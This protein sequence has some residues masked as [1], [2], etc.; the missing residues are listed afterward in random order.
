[1][2]GGCLREGTGLAA[3][4][5]VEGRQTIWCCPMSKMDRSL[6]RC[7]GYTTRRCLGCH[8]AAVATD[9]TDYVQ[10]V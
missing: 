6:R 7:T 5:E 8:F 9:K 4:P 1:M 3:L 10:P 2:T